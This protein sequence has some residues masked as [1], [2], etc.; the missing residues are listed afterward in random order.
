MDTSPPDDLSGLTVGHILSALAPVLEQAAITARKAAR[1]DCTKNRN[2]AIGTALDLDYL[3]S[4]ARAL[5]DAAIVL[6]RK[7]GAQ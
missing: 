5:Y 3:L 1:I 2:Q 6:H 7:A 4:S